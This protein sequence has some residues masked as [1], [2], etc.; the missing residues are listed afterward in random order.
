MLS[1]PRSSKFLLAAAAALFCLSAHAASFTYRIPISHLVVQTASVTPPA[2]TGS[3][4]ASPSSLSFPATSAGQTSS[5]QTVTLSNST[6]QAVTVSSASFGTAN[7]AVS[8]NNC[9]SVPAGGNCTLQAVFSPGSAVAG[10]SILTDTLTIQ[11]SSGPYTVSASATVATATPA[12]ASVSPSSL[13]FQ[14]YQGATIASQQVTITNSGGSTLTV[15]APTETTGT[16]FPFVNNCTSGLAAGQSCT[17]SVSFNPSQT[18]NYSDTLA[19][20]TSNG[21]ANVALSGDSLIPTGHI[22]IANYGNSTVDA[23]SIDAT[24]GAIS[25]CATTGG[26]FT[27]PFDINVSGNTAY[28]ANY[29]G[30][31]VTLC[32]VSN[33]VLSNC[34]VTQGFGG[35][36]D[37]YPHNGFVY[38]VGGDVQACTATSSNTLTGCSVVAGGLSTPSS[39]TF[40]NGRAYIT[41]TTANEI[42]SCTANSDGTLTGCIS[43]ASGSVGNYPE[44]ITFYNGKALVVPESGPN[45][46]FL[47]TVDSSTGVFTSCGPTG[48][49]VYNASTLVVSNN[50]AYIGN[51]GNSTVD[52]CNMSSTGVLSNCATVGN[53]LFSATIGVAL[54]L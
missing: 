9:T 12:L 46:A 7:F 13:T 3:V 17:I 18:G 54:G 4:L 47:C 14:G 25:N 32:D 30:N 29:G 36:R 10:G 43:T 1:R 20:T 21:S 35:V 11:T 53:N 19:V 40:Y 42:V 52:V 48:S 5:P 6:S 51:Y 8:A 26:N 38:V 27:G 33:G 22:F 44:G 28:V 16:N 49:N 45:T 50:F 39:I 2:S 37:V 15:N 31:S 34:A 24:T 23:C 41:N